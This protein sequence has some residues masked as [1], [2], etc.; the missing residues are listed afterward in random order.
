M[1]VSAIAAAFAWR[2]AGIFAAIML[3]G[4]L[5]ARATFL[6]F[7]AAYALALLS[8]PLGRAGHGEAARR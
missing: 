2:D 5:S 8:V 7:A 3:R 4:V 1:R 6:F